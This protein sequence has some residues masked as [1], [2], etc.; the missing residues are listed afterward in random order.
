[1]KKGKDQWGRQKGGSAQPCVDDPINPP[2]PKHFKYL[3]CDSAQ[4]SCLGFL[5][6]HRDA[7]EI[8]LCFL[9]SGERL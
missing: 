5:H 1:M 8:K 4:L 3:M 2:H 7:D 6:L 9:L